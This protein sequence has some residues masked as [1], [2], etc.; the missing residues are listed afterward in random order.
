MD[1]RGRPHGLG[2]RAYGDG[3]RHEGRWRHGSR[4]GQGAYEAADGFR[5]VGAF[6]GDVAEGCAGAGG[7]G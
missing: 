1:A 4:H 2:A 6:V 7:R 5:Y 3:G